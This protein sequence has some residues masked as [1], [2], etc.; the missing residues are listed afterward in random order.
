MHDAE[1]EAAIQRQY[2][3]RVDASDWPDEP[4]NPNPQHE[5][6]FEDEACIAWA[7][8]VISQDD[9][10]ALDAWFNLR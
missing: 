9:A 8:Q 5:G 1:N 2:S 4:M 3:T 10:R 6:E 7:D